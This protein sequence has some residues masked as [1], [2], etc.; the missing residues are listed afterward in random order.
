MLVDASA[1]VAIITREPGHE[2]LVSRLGRAATR[3]TSA[4]AI[5]EAALG[6]ARKLSWTAIEALALVDEFLAL[7]DIEVAVI[8]RQVGALAVEAFER[9]GK[10]RHAA[11]LNMGDC[12]AYACARN[13]SEPLLFVGD[14][15]NR[16]DVGIA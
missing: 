11:A 4:V 1:I 7:G 8:D 14:D 9:F 5:Y 6:I 10:G 16:T 2:A 12:F 3:A 13:R 15:F